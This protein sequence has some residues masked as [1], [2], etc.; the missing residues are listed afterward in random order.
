MVCVCL[1][2]YSKEWRNLWTHQPAA[3][4]S[5]I[6]QKHSA[7]H[8]CCDNCDEIPVS[9]CCLDHVVNCEQKPDKTPRTVGYPRSKSID[10]G[11]SRPKKTVQKTWKR[12]QI[13]F[14]LK[15][16]RPTPLPAEELLWVYIDGYIR[17]RVFACNTIWVCLKMGYTPQVHFIGKRL[18][19]R[20]ILGYSTL[21]Y[22]IFKPSPI[23]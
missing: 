16:W 20:G 6:C 21:L 15:H 10:C 4:L 9:N 12:P 17:V 7:V 11:I 13:R 23:P 18:I 3:S 14:K 19:N 5:H 1:S 8:H 22:P 2:K